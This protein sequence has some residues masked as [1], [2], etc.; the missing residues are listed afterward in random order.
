MKSINASFRTL[1]VVLQIQ[2]YGVVERVLLFWSFRKVWRDL[3]PPVQ[4]Q[5][6]IT[7]LAVFMLAAV[8]MGR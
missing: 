7:V 5:T 1:I 2:F 8:Y 4:D 3:H 6:Q